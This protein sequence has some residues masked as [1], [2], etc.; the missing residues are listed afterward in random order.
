M[1]RHSY[2]GAKS[3]LLVVQEKNVELD[4]GNTGKATIT[5]N[6][7][8]SKSKSISTT[9]KHSKGSVS[10]TG[11][12]GGLEVKGKEGPKFKD[13]YRQQVNT[14]RVQFLIPVAAVVLR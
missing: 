4:I 6:A 1:L 13:P 14:Q 8:G 9:G 11:G 5:V 10:N 7:D 12:G 2:T 3:G